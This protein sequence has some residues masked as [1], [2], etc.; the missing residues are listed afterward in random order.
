MK[1]LENSCETVFVYPFQQW[2]R[3]DLLRG[4]AKL[5]SRLRHG[6]LTVDF[7]AGCSSCSMTDSFVTD[8]VLIE[9]AVCCWHLHRLFLQTT[10]YLY[11]WLSR[12]LKSELKMKM[13]EVDGGHVPQCP[14]AGDTTAFQSV[15]RPF[16]LHC[17]RTEEN[18]SNREIFKIQNTTKL[19]VYVSLWLLHS[20][21]SDTFMLDPESMLLEPGQKQ[22]TCVCVLL[23]TIHLHAEWV[24]ACLLSLDVAAR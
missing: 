22:V 16:L 24:E 4:W 15:R 2:R 3:Q 13:L 11:S 18:F 6:A 7:R 9:R 1:V 20:A 21:H 14:V 8:A 12:F 17:V 23:S 5:D 19:P 10:Q